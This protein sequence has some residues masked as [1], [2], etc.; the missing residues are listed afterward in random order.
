[1][2]YKVQGVSID[3][4]NTAKPVMRASREL[5]DFLHSY[6]QVGRALDFGCGKLRYA[7]NIARL[8]ESLTLVDSEEQISRTQVLCGERTDIRTY[9]SRHW[10][11]SRVLDWSEFKV[12]GQ[13]YDFVLCANVLSAIPCARRRRQILQTLRQRLARGGR[14]VFVTQF[15]NTYFR[16]TAR[17]STATPHLDGWILK[18]RRGAFYYGILPPDKLAGLISRN[19]FKI[20]EVRQRGES[21]VLIAGLM[22]ER[23][24]S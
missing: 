5:V 4:H 9:A 20:H 23:G 24:S 10:K 19:G 17:K 12:D 7:W 13:C 11:D 14:A 3:A 21:V 1:V 18:T 16:D 15:K 22:S 8:C 6:T 2:R